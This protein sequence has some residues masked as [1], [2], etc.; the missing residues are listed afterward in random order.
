MTARRG[1]PAL[2]GLALALAVAACTNEPAT[3]AAPAPPAGPPEGT[4]AEQAGVVWTSGMNSDGQLGREVAELD[5]SLAPVTTRRSDR[6][7]GVRAVAGGGR[8]SLAVLE[9]GTV[10]AWGANDH[11]QL[12]DGTT[13]DRPTPVKVR[14]ADGRPGALTGVVAVSANS[15][16][17]MALRSDGT[18]VTFG[19]GDAGQRGTGTRAAPLIPTTV[20]AADRRGP[21]R[22]ITAIAADGRTELALTR[23][24]RVL[25]WGANTF[26]M[27]GDGTRRP[28]ALPG[29]VKGLEGE[30]ALTGV[31]RIAM[32]GQH[33]LAVLRDGRLAA[34]GRN[35]LGQLGDGTR[36]D[37]PVPDVVTGVG[38]NGQLGGVASISAAEKHNYAL[39]KDGSA[40][41]WGNNSAGQLGDGSAKLRTIPV[42]I[43]SGHGPLLR[44]VQQVFAGEAYGVAV[45]SDG[46]PMTWGAGGRGQ[47]AS[48][49]RQP[50]NRP[51]TLV[52]A[53]GAPLRPVLTAGVGERHLLLVMRP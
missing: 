1:S 19:K 44:N 46:S 7:T 5:P 18:V 14:A 40:V 21:L 12:G 35:D 52:M 16:F 6:L 42:P 15:D 4:A 28:R 36:R 45:L 38:G 47:L 11:G 17:S 33:G 32:G 51:G 49:N 34:W 43:V 22:G 2:L 26:G 29:P 37:R 23:S 9:G 27:L 50:R 25:S 13:V 53:H 48:G 39:L 8:H 3:S 24:G 20:R 10:V 31:T 41:A 30:G